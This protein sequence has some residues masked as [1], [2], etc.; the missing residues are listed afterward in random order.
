MAEEKPKPDAKTKLDWVMTSNGKVHCFK[1]E[2]SNC[3]VSGL[4]TADQLT[5]FHDA[6]L[7]EVTKEINGLLERAARTRSD[8]TT[9]LS[10]IAVGNGLM[11]AWTEPTETSPAS[12]ADEVVRALQI[13]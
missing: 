6:Q 9:E 12:P 1:S 3:F 5:A 2:T 4:Y 11:L 7:A 13:S 8:P 10:L